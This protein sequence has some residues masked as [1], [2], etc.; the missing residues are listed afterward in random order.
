MAINLG[1]GG[2]LKATFEGLKVAKQAATMKLLSGE[3]V[4]GFV[5]GEPANEYVVVRA[6]PESQI[7]T[8]LVRYAA[9]ATIEVTGT[10]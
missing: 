3:Q 4:Y 10:P 2:T 9:I 7:H 1:A 6:A 8:V 5:V